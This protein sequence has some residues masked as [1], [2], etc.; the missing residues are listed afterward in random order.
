M[1]CPSPFSLF[2]CNYSK[3][4][5]VEMKEIIKKKCRSDL[6]NSIHV[7]HSQGSSLALDTIQTW[8]YDEE[9]F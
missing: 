7:K 5:I 2:F 1:L 9:A 6:P 3:V 8:F 4:V